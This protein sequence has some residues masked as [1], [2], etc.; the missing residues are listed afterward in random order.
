MDSK[1][2]VRF[3]DLGSARLGSARFGSARLGSVRLDVDVRTARFG[4]A[5]LGSVAST[6][7]RTDLAS[8]GPR[9]ARRRPNLKNTK[10]FRF[11]SFSIRN[12]RKTIL[13]MLRGNIDFETVLVE[14]GFIGNSV[15]F[16]KVVY[17]PRNFQLLSF[18]KDL[19]R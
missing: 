12:D 3:L 19:K 17:P 11:W 14:V 10:S 15:N 18:F 6:Y 2:D 8:L 16:R 1:R 13:R 7:G 5:Q 9:F 4:S